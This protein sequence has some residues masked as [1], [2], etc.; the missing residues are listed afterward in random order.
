MLFYPFFPQLIAGPIVQHK[1]IIP[2]LNFLRLGRLKAR[3]LTIGLSIFTLG[4]FKKVAIA[5]S[6]AQ[7]ANPLFIAVDHGTTLSFFESWLAAISYSLQLYFDFSGYSDMAIGLGR[8]FNLKL[9]RNFFSP[10]KAKNIIDF[11]KRWHITLSTFLRDYLYIPLGG[12]R[13]GKLSQFQNILITMLLGGLWHGASW[14][15]VVWGGLHGVYIVLNHLWL[16]V[17]P[18]IP[19]QLPKFLAHLLGRS[20]TLMAVMI[21]WVYFR[22]ETFS[23]ANS[24]LKSMFG[25]NGISLL[26]RL[27]GK[28]NAFSALIPSELHYNG[29]FFNELIPAGKSCMLVILIGLIALY[30]PNTEQVFKRTTPVIS[31]HRFNTNQNALLW[32][33]NYIWAIGLGL[34]GLISVLCISITNEFIYFQF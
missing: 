1:D 23:S 34:M 30:A 24:I 16:S 4:L 13:K 28:L 29:V 5:D 18:S 7:I 25:F 26:K 22:A 12:N 11:W 17:K 6:C 21:A 32:A 2:Q 9:P 15:F 19:I 20:I 8:M 33:N 3:H 27:E 10:Y 31:H 14:T